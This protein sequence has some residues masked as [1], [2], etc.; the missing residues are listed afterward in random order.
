[1]AVGVPVPGVVARAKMSALFPTR[2]PSLSLEA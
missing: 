2:H 1:M